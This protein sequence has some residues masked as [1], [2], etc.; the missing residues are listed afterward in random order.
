MF[1]YD[2]I[3]IAD[4]LFECLM[5]TNCLFYY[6]YR[7]MK[8]VVEDLNAQIKKKEENMENLLQK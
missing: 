7:N 2:F 8:Q 1:I 5:E 4:F 3:Y 6:I